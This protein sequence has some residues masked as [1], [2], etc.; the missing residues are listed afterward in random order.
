MNK[1][2]IMIII[3]IIAVSVCATVGIAYAND[4]IIL[5]EKL[6]NL[7]EEDK[8][9]KTEIA[10][11]SDTEVDFRKNMQ[12]KILDE[13]YETSFVGLNEYNTQKVVYTNENGDEFEYDVET[14]KLCE[15]VISSNRVSKSEDSIDID[16]AHKIALKLLPED[17]NIDE[18][19]QY[20]YRQTSKGYFFWYIR[21]FGKYRSTDSFSATIGFDGSVVDL[22]DSTHEFSDKNINFDEEYITLKIDEFVKE[23]GADSVDFDHATV[24]MSNGKVCVS[25]GYEYINEEGIVTA[26]LVSDIP[27]E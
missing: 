5:E 16:T 9:V 26:S 15:A 8:A 7:S 12:T 21:Y 18:Y 22:S 2:I 4:G 10:K 27:L 13:T 17:V 25:V 11:Y 19:T 6:Q 3:S 20:A 24:L 14:G 1:K 23:N